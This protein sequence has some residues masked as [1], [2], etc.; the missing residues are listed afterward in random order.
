MTYTPI[1]TS[2][3]AVRG[4]TGI[5]IADI[6]D[7]DMADYIIQT[8]EDKVGSV[9]SG[10]NNAVKGE[11]SLY[12]SCH[13]SITRLSGGLKRVGV[14]D[15]MVDTDNQFYAMFNQIIKNP[16]AHPQSIKIYGGLR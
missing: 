5:T 6:S 7:N 14:G 9:I 15:I 12:Y 4:L 3:L 16:S 11:A 8:A 13:L 2:I 1:Y 10:A